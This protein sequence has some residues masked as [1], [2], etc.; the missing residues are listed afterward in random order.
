MQT[1]FDQNHDFRDKDKNPSL[2]FWLKEIAQAGSDDYYALRKVEKSKQEELKIILALFDAIM[3]IP[4]RLKE[5]A[6]VKI[7]LNW[8]KEELIKT[9]RDQASHP[10]TQA[11][12]FIMKAYQLNYNALL[13]FITALEE[14]TQ[15]CQFPN[16]Q[17]LRDFYTY[18]YGIRERMI[19]K[20]LCP[21][22]SDIM[23]ESVH[24]GAY[25]LALIDNL[26]YIRERAL[27]TYIFFSDEETKSLNI[28]KNLILSLKLSPDLMTLFEHQIQKAK[29]QATYL[30]Q[31]NQG[32]WLV[33]P[34]FRIRCELAL[35]WGDLIKDE[36]FPLFTHHI[37]LTALRKWWYSRK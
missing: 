13:Q 37:E 25:C 23:K 34:F 26:K 30:Y 19:L 10:L 27:K 12:F 32:N 17:S 22:Q 20:I 8:W 18:T 31:K 14:I 36:K 21:N 2:N 9:Q 16:E 3:K 28:D 35:R 11:L 33:H 7:K 5:D 29:E 6:L 4:F 15:Y 24:H 1:C